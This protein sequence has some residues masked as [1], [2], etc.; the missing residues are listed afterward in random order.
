MVDFTDSKIAGEVTRPW[1]VVDVQLGQR[2]H[3]FCTG[4]P[5]TWKGKNYEADRIVENG[6]LVDD[7]TLRLRLNNEGYG[8][9]GA[10]L[11]GEFHGGQVS[12]WGAPRAADALKRF[13]PVGY[14]KSGYEKGNI[15]EEPFLLFKGKITEVPEIGLAIGLV[16][17]RKH[18]GGFP[19]IRIMPPLANHTAPAGT[20]ITYHNR[21]YIVEKR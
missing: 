4:G 2:M 18:I 17:T 8:L 11:R 13:Y 16:A 5:A 14:V 7:M 3:H 19:S 9:T 1:Y 21:V 6:V 15:A 12:V 20:K 10:A